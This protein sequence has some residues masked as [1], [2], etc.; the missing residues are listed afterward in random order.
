[1]PKKPEVK[2]DSVAGA[3]A[4][5]KADRQ[6][7][8]AACSTELAAL[9]AKHKCRIVVGYLPDGVAVAPGVVLHQPVPVLED[10][11]QPAPKSA[12]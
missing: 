5:I 10:A 8:L 11:P 6:K 4:A 3:I 9:L 12:P 1:M 7:R 2:R